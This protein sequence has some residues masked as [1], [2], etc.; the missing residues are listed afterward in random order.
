MYSRI[1]VVFIILFLSFIDVLAIAQQHASDT[2]QQM[3]EVVVT[4]TRRASALSSLPYSAAVLTRQDMH[5]LP[6][7]TLPEAMAGLPGVFI[8]KTNHAGGSPFVRGL[9]GNQTL[10]VVDGIRLNNSIFRYG[11]NQY[12]ALVDPEWAERIEVVKGSGS[13]QYGSDALTGVVQVLTRNPVFSKDPQWRTRLGG[14]LAS[15]GIEQGLRPELEYSGKRIALLAGASI[16]RFGDLP[17]GDTTGFQRPSGYRERSFDA[18]LRA[19]LG[20]G[21]IATASV[22]HL[23]QTGVPV[24]HKYILESFAVNT[25]DPI[26][27]SFGYIRT[28]KAIE[29]SIP[30]RISLFAAWQ[31]ISEDRQSRK[32]GSKVLRIETDRART[33]SAGAD[34]TFTF[35]SHWKSN[36]GIEVYADKVTST[37]VD[38]DL[39][40]DVPTRLRGLYPDGARYLQASAYSLHHLTYGRFTVEAGTRYSFY[41]ARI[42]DN[43]LGSVEIRPDAWVFQGGA[44]YRVSKRIHVFLHASEGFRAPNIDDMGTLG[45]VDFRYE[46]PAYDLQ[47]ERSLNTEF[48][49]RHAAPRLSLQASVFRTTLRNLITRIKTSEIVSGYDVYVKRNVERGYI[50]GMETQGDWRIGD[51]WRVFGHASWLYGQSV[52]RN[53]PLR[54][55]PPFN[56]RLA[57]EYRTS[58]WRAGFLHDHASAQRRLAAGDVA[59]NRI[60]QGGTPGFNLLHAFAARDFRQLTLRLQLVNLLN[61]DYRTHGSGINGQGRSL[62]VSALM[63]W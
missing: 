24:Y 27:R 63:E 17:G 43:T 11:P 23:Q 42:S 8:Q 25:S 14:R 7:R 16:R 21:W 59:D 30:L 53:E 47:P 2:V 3:D 6:S 57:L 45:I 36:S 12:L 19:D 62:Q 13:V 39:E 22:Q 40:F 28:E 44:D 58:N 32:N 4:A 20:R 52:T 49:L 55:I 37:R 41:Q 18:K 34:L 60:P 48:G 54:R 61:A 51:A 29:G 33:L 1:G 50:Y 10:L 56:T 35:S 46:R 31:R 5:R 38:T 15:A 9:T 26:G